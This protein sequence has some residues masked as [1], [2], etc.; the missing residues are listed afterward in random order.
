[1]L[2]DGFGQDDSG[3]AVTASGI[4]WLAFWEFSD[5]KKGILWTNPETDDVFAG[6]SYAQPA[7]LPVRPSWA[8]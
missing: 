8:R 3:N 4:F 7:G 2:V 5:S 6:P 1:M